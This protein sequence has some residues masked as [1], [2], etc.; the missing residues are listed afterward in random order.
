LPDFVDPYLDSRTGV[1]CNRV[2]ATTHS[3]LATAEADLTAFAAIELAEN[4]VTVTRDL[5]QLRNIHHRLFRDVFE[6]AGEL[7]T[8][9]MRK[10]GDTA[11]EFFMP[12]SRLDS[13][14]GFEFR[15][16]A[17][18]SFLRGMDKD[19]F[20][21]RLAHHYDQVNYLHP[22]REGNGRTQRI[23]WSQI[24]HAAGFELDWRGVS[25]AANDRACRLAMEKQDLSELCAMFD[26]IA[27]P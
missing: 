24:A 20:V 11:A 18:D 10:A 8:V 9:D 15:E 2:G 6:W 17:D 1:L 27:D 3:A 14:A 13:G 26:A 25:G 7:R 19:Q 16:L 4:P 22:F 23:F 21:L 5:R 12:V